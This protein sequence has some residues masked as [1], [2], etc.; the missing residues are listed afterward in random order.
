[1][2]KTSKTEITV[3]EILDGATQIARQFS[4]TL[5]IYTFP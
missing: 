4:I 1:M 2:E 3:D 5:G